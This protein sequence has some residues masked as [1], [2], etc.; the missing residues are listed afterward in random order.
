MKYDR[1]NLLQVARDALAVARQN[2]QKHGFVEPVGLIFHK[3]G[4]SHIYQFKFQNLNEKRVSQ[5]MFREL[6]IKVRARA[7]VVVSESWVKTVPHDLSDLTKSIADDPARQEAIIIEAVS[8]VARIFIMQLFVRN[9]SG[10]VNFESPFEPDHGFDWI[11]EWL[12]N[13]VF[14]GGGKHV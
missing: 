5:E 13:S 10:T 8:D 11:S 3:G 4:L 12:D 9:E 6:L 2:L 14:S 1:K 7:A